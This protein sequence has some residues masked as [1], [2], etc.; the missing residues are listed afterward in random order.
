VLAAVDDVNRAAV[1]IAM[2]LASCAGVEERESGPATPARREAAVPKTPANPPAPVRTDRT[3]Y[4]LT[5]G[6]QG[7][8]ATIVSTL[9][10]PA[11]TTL[12]ILNCNG[13]K[14]V[15]LQRLVSGAWVWSWTVAMN[16]C[17]SPPIVVPAG[18][19]HSASVYVHERSGGVSYPAGAKMIESG[20]YRIVWTGVLTSF[21]ANREGFGPELPL[22]LRV[23][24][25]F[26]IEVPV[27]R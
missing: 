11:N 25:P 17:L 5:N 19:E 8:E 21:D 23:S 2:L 12:Y 1:I 24:A 22:E 6:P 27:G 9:R 7:L 20:T 18:G 16:A 10:A 3:R 26:E 14:S 4:V 13:A 15:T